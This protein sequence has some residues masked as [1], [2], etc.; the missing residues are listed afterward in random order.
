ML[1]IANYKNGLAMQRFRPE[2]ADPGL[3]VLKIKE[4]GQG[5]CAEDAEVTSMGPY[6]FMMEI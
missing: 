2:G 5:Q 4:L 1:D 6:E 3:P